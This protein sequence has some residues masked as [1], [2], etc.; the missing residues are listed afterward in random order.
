MAKKLSLVNDS[1]ELREEILENFQHGSIE[2]N[3][4]DRC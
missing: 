2:L 4:F 1:V 3:I